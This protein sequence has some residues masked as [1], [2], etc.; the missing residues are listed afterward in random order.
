MNVTKLWKGLSMVVAVSLAGLL[1]GCPEDKEEEKK[2]EDPFK[3]GWV[4]ISPPGD[5]G[6]TYAHDLGR[7]QVELDL[8]NVKTSYKENV[9]E[10]TE[11]VAAIEAL[12]AE[13]NKIIFTTSWGYMDPTLEV[14]NK[15]P[16][17]KFE[18]CSGY[19]TSTNMANYFGRMYQVRYLTGIVAGSMTTANKIGFV[20]AF[21]LPEVVRGINAFTLG[22]RSV[23]P[24]AEVHV[25][26]TCTWYDP[27]LEATAAD[28]LLDDGCD[29]L[30][31][32]QDS[33][34]TAERANARGKYAIGYDSDTLSFVPN[35]I[36]TSAIWHW[37]VYYKERVQA[38]RAGTWTSQSY[39][40]AASTGIAGLGAYNTVV[41]QQVR[42]AVETK[43]ALI[44]AGTWDVFNGPINKQDGTVWVAAGADISDPDKLSMST[45]VEGVVGST[46]ACN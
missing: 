16:G 3:A 40:G 39:W 30:A 10:G 25:R 38:A 22:V 46:A 13:G 42:D 8:D 5:M 28:A 23:N 7:L 9:P 12:V 29:I 18:H 2:T 26:W 6:W 24:A 17:V 31:Q 34:A 19:K 14:A 1:T 36:L 43:R 45:F 33:T 4:Y 32:H 44:A 11:A 41:P 27:T 21:P 15:Y 20:A 35:A 37:G